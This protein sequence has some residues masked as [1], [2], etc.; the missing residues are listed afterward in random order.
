MDPH[1]GRDLQQHADAEGALCHL[2]DGDPGRQA[3][4]RLSGVH[5]CRDP[6][7]CQED[8][9]QVFENINMVDSAIEKQLLREQKK[10]KKLEERFTQLVKEKS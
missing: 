3:A 8:S 2:H 1:P 10:C 5:A 6:T 9:G 4:G 7:V